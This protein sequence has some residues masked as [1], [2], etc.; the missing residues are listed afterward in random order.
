MYVYGDNVIY[1]E[2]FWVEHIP[3][4]IK[5]LIG[6]NNII[7]IYRIQACNSI[8]CKHFCIGFIDF[9][10]KCFADYTNL[11]CY[12]NVKAMIKKYWSIFKKVKWCKFIVLFAVSIEILK[13]LK[14]HVFSEIYIGEIYGGTKCQPSL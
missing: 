4:E 5:K 7:N 12:C 13:T 10:L 8:M 3:E 6:N 14:Y 11:F 2:T 9:I 1:L